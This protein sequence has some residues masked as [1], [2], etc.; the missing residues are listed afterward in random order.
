M[1]Q[2]KRDETAK[3]PGPRRYYVGE[4]CSEAERV[5]AFLAAGG[6]SRATYFNWSRKLHAPVTHSGLG[7]ENEDC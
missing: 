6:G 2:R 7:P 1:P 3:G 4:L 5:R